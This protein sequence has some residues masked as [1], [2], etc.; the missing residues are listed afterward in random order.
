M[1]NNGQYIMGH[2]KDSPMQFD[3]EWW[4]AWCPLSKKKA[5]E[6]ESPT[7]PVES[8]RIPDG[9]EVR[10]GLYRVETT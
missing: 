7:G 3:Y 10:I 5:V 1:G 8:S 4:R 2:M 9:I 6:N